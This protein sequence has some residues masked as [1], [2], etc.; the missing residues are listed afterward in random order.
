MRVL[1]TTMRQAQRLKLQ[2]RRRQIVLQQ[3][4]P[5][6]SAVQILRARTAAA[7]QP[8]GQGPAGH[9]RLLPSGVRA[10]SGWW[11]SV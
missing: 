2:Q 6:I 4:Q 11:G 1:R 3:P 10:L 8:D 9:P 5:S 7:Q